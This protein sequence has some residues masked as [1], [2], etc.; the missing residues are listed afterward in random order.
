MEEAI[1][2]G[3]TLRRPLARAE[4][5]LSF[6]NAEGRLAVPHSEVEI[7]RVVFREGGSD[8]QLNRTSTRLRDILDICRD[9]GLGANSYTVIEQ[10]MVERILSDRPDERRHMF[11]E[12]AGVGRYK[13]RRKSALRRLEGAEH[14]LAR[15]Q[16]LVLEV[17]TKVRS[18][19]RQR[20]R[21][22]RY[23]EYRKRRLDLE[24]AVAHG[25][26][27]RVEALLA[28]TAG[29]LD[30][31]TRDEPASRAAL[32]T[33]ETELERRRLESGE[34]GRERNAAALRLEELNRMIADRERQ[35]AVA[36]ERR[37]HAQRRLVQISAERDE[38]HARSGTL[39]AELISLEQERT[40]QG[41]VVETLTQRV[42]EVQERQQ[43]LRQL[44]TDV[45]LESAEAAAEARA[46]DAALRLEQLELEEAEV[47]FELTQLAE[48][49]DLFAEQSRFLDE[50][51]LVL[52]AEH[53]AAAE[54]LQQARAGETEAR[55]AFTAAEDLAN[56]LASQ[57]AALET[58]EREYR[59]YAPA[60]AL[61]M[62]NRPSL[63][64]L[65][66]PV[67][68]F[69]D[70]PAERAA[71]LEGALGGLLQVLL[72]RDPGALAAVR[73][74]ID[75]TQAGEG[76][77]PAGARQAGR[78]ERAED[79]TGVVALLP[80]ASLPRLRELIEALEF[81][82]TPP[83][84]P[85]IVGRRKKLARLRSEAAAAAA[86]AERLGQ[87]R[88]QA[89]ARVGEAE[90]R[91]REQ[92]SQ[93]EAAEL[94][95][96]RASADEVTRSGRAGRAQ[97]V[98]EELARRRSDLEAVVTRAVTEIAAS[99][100]RRDVLE[101]QLG[102]HRSDWQ[103]A[104]A[105]LTE[106]EAAW[107]EVREQEA[108]LRVA[109]AR[110]EGALSALDRR[111][112]GA[113]EDRD[114]ALQRLGALRA[115]EG[116]HQQTMASLEDVRSDAGG[117]LEELFRRRDGVAV[118]LRSHEEQLAA[119]ADASISLE[120]QVRNLR[121]STDERNELRHRLELQRA[122]ADA[123]ELRVRE[124][125]EAEWARPF[126]QLAAEASPVEIA[127]LE[128]ARAELHTI[129]TDIERLGPINMLA[130]EEYEEESRRLEF[131]TV[132]RDDLMKARDDL[133]SAIREINRT[134]RNL[135]TQ[136]FEAI[137]TNFSTT[138]RTLFEGGDCDVR[139]EDPDD[140]LESPIEISASPKGKRTQRIHLLSGGERALTALALLFAI[141]L[142]KPSP[143][144]VLDEV[145]APLDEANVIRFVQMLQTF[146]VTT[147]F[148]VITH[149]P[150]T[151]EAADWLYGVTMEEAGV[152]TIV[153][154]QLDDVLAAAT[155]V[156]S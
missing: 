123:Q 53:E 45:R 131:L 63:A 100:E 133:Q 107:E 119:A 101:Q 109:H 59:G 127:D 115:E 52:R 44:V 97:R 83:A 128:L 151:M 58:L 19:A 64:G 8:Y 122:E 34:L 76:G 114:Q 155:P 144:C 118:D 126:E 3:T 22:E 17:T 50:R 140:P 108:E 13:D 24:I 28:R 25:E 4:V 111:L 95:L 143:F 32:V 91:V 88:E 130:V 93:L 27:A 102:L 29:D 54:A 47:S 138:F 125:L 112:A 92:A 79:I 72:V 55:R 113:H 103:Q 16:D 94:E 98:R 135:F 129:V 84:E 75:R 78:K 147:Q 142:V 14:D 146:K 30:D 134:A 6:D 35:L 69:L 99:R 136:T 117:E 104:T 74:F 148:I 2:Q 82:G 33:A 85:V 15:L 87:A 156:A 73:T 21:A 90:T 43:V 141:Y 38:L 11:E 49:G 40:G 67:A 20:G 116:E 46:H 139:L 89:S 110:A 37:A 96:R 65:V 31:L 106:K 1:F 105:T 150:R 23:Q 61:A 36:D 145:D 71:S 42:L 7:R 124:R 137:R 5:A 86:D 57:L 51:V 41:G 10:G 60:V 68:E 121:R 12:A 26:L 18:L 48:Q 70:L 153:G 77:G 9:T 62:G 56:R 81:A 80:E 39:E 152:S 154:V 149:N 66:G 120:T 132:Q